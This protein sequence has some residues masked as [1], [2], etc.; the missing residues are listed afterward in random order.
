[1]KKNILALTTLLAI[2]EFNSGE[3]ERLARS[4]EL[5]KSDADSGTRYNSNNVGAGHYRLN[6]DNRSQIYGSRRRNMV[7][8]N[9]IRR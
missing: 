2:N 1:M 7:R 6:T 3:I 9:M 4:L 5:R 8:G